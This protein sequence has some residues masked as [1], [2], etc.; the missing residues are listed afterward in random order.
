MEEEEG[1][2]RVAGEETGMWGSL[3][4]TEPGQLPAPECAAL[5]S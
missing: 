5:R 4:D 2:I 1:S 3:V